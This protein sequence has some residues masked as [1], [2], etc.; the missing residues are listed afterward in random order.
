MPVGNMHTRLM[1]AKTWSPDGEGTAIL[2][3][4]GANH[5]SMQEGDIIVTDSTYYVSKDGFIDMEITP[6]GE[7]KM[8]FEKRKNLAYHSD[9]AA[10][11]GKL[12]ADEN[13]EIRS[14]VAQ[15]P[16]TPV[17]I[18]YQLGKSLFLAKF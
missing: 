13:A 9:D 11:L 10:T 16:N 18:L 5:D 3:D 1:Q 4:V 15:N 7:R 6:S 8:S 2:Q 17:E 14:Y 12:S